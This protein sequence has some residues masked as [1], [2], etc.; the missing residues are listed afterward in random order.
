M[1]SPR[2]AA[3][4]MLRRPKTMAADTSIAEVRAALDDDHQHMVLL[5]DGARLVGTVTPSDLPGPE[6]DGAAAQWA[7]LEGRTVAPEVPAADIEQVL[8]DQGRR[9]I[10]VVDGEYS[11]LG[12]LCL[13]QRGR[14]FC[15]DADIESRS[16]GCVETEAG[17]A[18]HSAGV[19]G[20]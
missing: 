2:T 12:L 10:A 7:R 9:R 4:V 6:S 1:S 14:G 20:R 5:T 13:K 15:S 16:R 11:L 8:V 17:A 19:T 18:A 3:D